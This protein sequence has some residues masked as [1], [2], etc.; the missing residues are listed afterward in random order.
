MSL[1]GLALFVVH[2]LA[3]KRETLFNLRIFADR[4]FAAA[5]FV[6][7]AMGL[8]LFGGMLLQPVLFEGLLQYPDVRHRPRDGAARHRQPARAC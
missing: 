5:S 8:S 7:G 1:A 2:S 6:G 3:S 4:N